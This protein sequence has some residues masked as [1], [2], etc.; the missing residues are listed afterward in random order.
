[1]TRWFNIRLRFHPLFVFIILGSLFTGYFLEVITLFII[2]IIHE[3]GHVTAAKGFGWR[4]QEIQLLPFGGVA[5]VEEQGTVRAYEEIVVA[6]AGPLQNVLMIGLGSAAYS[7]GLWSWEWSSYFIEA[8]LLLACFNLLPILPLDGGK[9]LQ[10]LLSFFL[11]YHKAIVWSTVG[12]FLMGGVVCG[13]AFSPLFQQGLQL[14]LFI[15]GLFLLYQNWVSYKHTP[16]HFLRFLMHRQSFAARHV[17]KGGVASPIVVQRNKTLGQILKMLM[18]EKY[19]LIY[20]MNEQGVIQAVISEQKLV[21]KFLKQSPPSSAVSE[22][23][24]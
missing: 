22:L 12:S 4:V 1:L 20:V 23:F 24:M 21:A 2:V 19:H 8:N 18:K 17:R 7:W 10:A 13:F 15:I 11:P 3:L 16:F 14:N 6:L 9:V 5:V